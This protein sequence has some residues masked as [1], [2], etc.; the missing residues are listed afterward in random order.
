MA[1]WTSASA[2][3][4][5]HLT[6]DVAP[7]AGL[8]AD[9]TTMLWPGV[10]PLTFPHMNRSTFQGDAHARRLPAH[11]VVGRGLACLL[12]ALG[13]RRTGVVGAEWKSGDENADDSGAPGTSAV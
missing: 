12:V 7:R 3:P 10:I 2:L 9:V 11:D 1:S 5:H 6:L 8:A 13:L 4:W